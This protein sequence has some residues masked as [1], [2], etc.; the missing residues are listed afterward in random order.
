MEEKA[1]SKL[2]EQE[3]VNMLIEAVNLSRPA[4][5]DLERKLKSNPD[6]LIGRISLLGY[7]FW[8]S[9]KE[10]TD[11]DLVR[12][13]TWF[14]KNA[15]DNAVLRNGPGSF[16]KGDEQITALW[17]ELIDSDS[18]N[19]EILENA[20]EYFKNKDLKLCESLYQKA[21][22]LEPKNP[23][24]AESLW[25]FHR[26]HGEHRK[27]YE[28]IKLALKNTR[29]DFNRWYLSCYF[30]ET[31]FEAGEIDEAR[32]A[33]ITVLEQSKIFSHHWNYGNAI[34][35]A[36]NILGRVAL[37]DGSTENAIEFLLKA[38]KSPGSPQLSTSGPNFELAQELLDLGETDVVLKY[39]K[40][41]KKLWQS[42]GN[43]L[44]KK[45]EKIRNGEK[46]TLIPP[47]D[48]DTKP[49]KRPRR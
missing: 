44:W 25:I 1:P 23:H 5:A 34:H 32:N 27:A 17:K 12:H 48:D 37:K 18:D 43:D 49:K 9:Q 33:A 16:L 38:G 2:R 39:L 31:A 24:W 21:L 4:I 19:V 40:D 22:N 30:C 35:I 46:V 11:A 47:P 8:K 29:F 41:C 3:L 28:Y 20:A 6:D 42:E 36:N 15:P 13:L 10:N 45:I 26:N 14:L 7:Y